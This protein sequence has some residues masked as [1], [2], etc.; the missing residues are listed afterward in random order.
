MRR[1]F[2]C[3]GISYYLLLLVYLI[4]D[5]NNNTRF[6]PVHVYYL[7][8]LRC[9]WEDNIKMDFQ[10]VGCG[11]FDWIKLAHDKNRWRAHV[12]AL[13]KLRFHKMRG[14]S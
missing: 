2:L 6:L 13:M 3:G 1:E 4:V 7:E 14:I 12:N 11:C 8:R 10:E 5:I 9:R